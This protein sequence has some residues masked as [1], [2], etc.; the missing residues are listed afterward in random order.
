MSGYG[1][2]HIYKVD[3]GWFCKVECTGS[4]KYTLLGVERKTP[5]DAYNSW[6]A[7][8]RLYFPSRQQ[9]SCKTK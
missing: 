6:C 8:Y 3:G 5:L 2:P 4:S 7:Q 9:W 1:K